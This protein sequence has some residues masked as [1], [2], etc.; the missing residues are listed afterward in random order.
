M[1]YYVVRTLSASK[2]CDVHFM[3]YVCMDFALTLVILN[4]VQINHFIFI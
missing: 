3:M 1:F 2:T 4:I